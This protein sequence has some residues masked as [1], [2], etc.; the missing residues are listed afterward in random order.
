MGPIEILKRARD[1][2]VSEGMLPDE[3]RTV[4]F[5]NTLI[6]A[7]YP[8]DICVFL[9][10]IFFVIFGGAR[11]IAVVIGL[12]PL[13]LNVVVLL[14]NHRGRYKLARNFTMIT[15]NLYFLLIYYYFGK[16]TQWE[17][18]FIV[19]AGLA[20]ILYP[21]RE[22]LIMY[23][24][25]A[26]SFIF[27]FSIK[28]YGP[29]YAGELEFPETLKLVNSASDSIL[30]VMVIILTLVARY[31][32][33]SAEDRLLESQEKIAGLTDKLKI[34]LPHQFV[35]ALSKGDRAAESDYKRRRL[36]IFFS[37]VRGFTAWTDK[38]EPEETREILN[39]YLSEMSTIANKW[40]G[41]IDKF[42]GDSIMIFFGDPEF[43]N[44]KDHAIRCVKMALEMQA[45]M[46]ELRNEWED[47]GQLEPLH[48]RIGINTGYATVGNFGSKDR[49]NYTILGSAVNLA[50]RLETAS[51]PD[52]ITISH[53]TWSMIKSEIACEPKGEIS[54]KGFSEPVKIYEV[55]GINP[56]TDSASTAM[57]LGK[58][59]NHS[60]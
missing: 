19:S 13:I 5:L 34:Y 7:K 26:L 52:K 24:M 14:M 45:K 38:L 56:S 35:D 20:A 40:G 15:V 11:G 23:F 1:I 9:S 43:T 16:G 33:I 2:G 32:T 21:K 29:D 37:D 46:N 54:I 42:I 60:Y 39:Q 28:L 53:M 47:E 48:I 25:I 30:F 57:I 10:N 18:F 3:A 50:S 17:F 27:F 49:L 31:S 8:T 12:S 55:A 6:L 36:T 59:D 44:D 41:T 22:S 4:R 58:G 51:N